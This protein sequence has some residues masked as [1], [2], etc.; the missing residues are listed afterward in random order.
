V[1]DYVYMVLSTM[2]VKERPPLYM[3]TALS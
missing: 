1:I 3:I 2:N